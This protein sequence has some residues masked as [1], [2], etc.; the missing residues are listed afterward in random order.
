MKLSICIIAVL[1]ASGVVITSPSAAALEREPVVPDAVAA[2]DGTFQT[3]SGDP[4]EIIRDDDAPGE[5]TV[6]GQASNGEMIRFLIQS[7]SVTDADRQR[8]LDEMMLGPETRESPSYTSA[9]LGPETFEIN[10]PP[11]DEDLSWAP[12]SVIAT[13]TSVAALSWNESEFSVQVLGRSA[14]T[15]ENGQAV[16]TDLNPDSTYSA[17]MTTSNY[18]GKDATMERQ[19]TI[20]IST[21]PDESG[22]VAPMTYQNWTT[23]YVHK[24]FISDDRISAVY[25]G[26]YPTYEFGGDDRGYS[27]PALATP[28]DPPNYRTMMFGNV[29]WDQSIPYNFTWTRNVGASKIYNNGVLQQTLYADTSDMLVK[30]IQV[31]STYARA[32]FDQWSSN[33]HCAALDV[34]YGGAIRFNEWVEY[35][36]SGTVAVDGYRFKAPEHEMYGRFNT[37]SGMDTWRA[38]SRRPNDGFFCL[39]GNICGMDFYQDSASF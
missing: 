37:S 13:T 21:L 38:I 9:P 7:T 14:A 19:R 28:T 35:Y 39:L 23:A 5:R 25:C 1:A 31:G 29:N 20:E 17:T 12:V 22:D 8:I 27:F 6:I 10:A 33:P 15:A 11:L 36:R 30:D 34:N 4:V 2:L 32:N 26:N 24:A 16:L 18:L 3:A